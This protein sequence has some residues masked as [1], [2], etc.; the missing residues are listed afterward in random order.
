MALLLAA[1][2]ENAA[3]AA[4]ELLYAITTRNNLISF[5]SDAPGTILSA[6]AINGLQGAERIRGVSVGPNGSLYGLGSSSRLYTINPNTGTATQVGSGQFSTLLNGQAFGVAVGLILTSPPANEKGRTFQSGLFDTLYKR[7][8]KFFSAA[9][10]RTTVN[11]PL[12][13]LKL[14]PL[15]VTSSGDNFER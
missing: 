7:E 12:S 15:L 1:G 11:T 10:P 8:L 3:L 5:Y 14:C 6:R 2:W 4:H 13:Y 9:P